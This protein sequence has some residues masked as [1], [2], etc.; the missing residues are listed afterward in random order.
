M[1]TFADLPSYNRNGS[2]LSSGPSRHGNREA[3]NFPFSPL[4]PIAGVDTMVAELGDEEDTRPI[5][6]CYY[7][8]FAWQ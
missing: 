3:S 1:A 5:V 4:D 7:R 2:L 8:H 6:D